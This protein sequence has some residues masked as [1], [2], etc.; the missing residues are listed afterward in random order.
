MTVNKTKMPDLSKATRPSMKNIK[1]IIHINRIKL[2]CTYKKFSYL[3]SVK[4]FIEYS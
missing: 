4:N 3:L 2:E 1:V